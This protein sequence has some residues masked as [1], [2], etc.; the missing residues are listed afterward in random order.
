MFINYIL[1]GVDDAE[2][3]ELLNPKNAYI[4]HP[5]IAKAKRMLEQQE[6]KAKIVGTKFIDLTLN[7]V[8][9]KA[10]KL[11]EYCGKGNYVLI[12]FWA[13]WCGPCRAEMPNVKENYEKYHEKGFD[14]VGISF[15]NNAEAWKKAIED[16]DIHWIHLSDLKAWKSEAGKTYAIDAIPASLLV[17]PQGT[18]IARDLREEALGEKLKEIYGF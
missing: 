2:L 7:D 10:H 3:K 4:N 11:S 16:M 12:D 9:G 5:A 18:I 1:G 14:I 8:D 17:D 6:K 13:S 15:D